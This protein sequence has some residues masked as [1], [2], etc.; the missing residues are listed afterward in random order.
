MWHAKLGDWQLFS[1]NLKEMKLKEDMRSQSQS[2][3][4]KD[5]EGF[6]SSLND[7]YKA[8]EAAMLNKQM[9]DLR[10]EG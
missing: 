4:E 3:P 7:S 5:G 2:S 6:N 9:E 8:D 1:L 10:R